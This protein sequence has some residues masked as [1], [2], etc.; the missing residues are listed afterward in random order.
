MIDFEPCK[1]GSHVDV[2]P[3]VIVPSANDVQFSTGITT[4]SVLPRT[5]ILVES[6]NKNSSAVMVSLD[7]FNS[8]LAIS[9]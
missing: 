1:D 4:A 6:I 7:E 2:K 9:P 8:K 3:G 5:S